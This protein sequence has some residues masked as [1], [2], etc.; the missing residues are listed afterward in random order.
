MCNSEEGAV[1]FAISRGQLTEGIDFKNELCRAVVIVGVPEK[2]INDL[3]LNCAKDYHDK[4]HEK[5][6]NN[7]TGS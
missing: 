2:P 6:P 4:Q 7:L 5:D 3:E 1:L